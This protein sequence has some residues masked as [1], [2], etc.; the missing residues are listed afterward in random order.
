MLISFTGAQSSGKTTLLRRFLEDHPWGSVD[1][2]TRR[3]RRDGFAINDDETDS[4]GFNSESRTKFRSSQTITTRN[5]R[6][7][8]L[9]ICRIFLDNSTFCFFIISALYHWV[10][11]IY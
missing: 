1:E 10:K 7:S 3:I 9:N 11:S 2:V 4:G 8:N 6:S 5:S